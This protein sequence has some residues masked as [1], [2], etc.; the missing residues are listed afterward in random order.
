MSHFISHFLSSPG[1]SP[2]TGQD[3]QDGREVE[4]QTSSTHI[5]WRYVGE[6]NWTDLIALSEL[7][8]PEGPPG[9]KGDTGEAGAT[10]AP[11]ADGADGAD[12]Q[13]VTITVLTDPSAFE[14]ATPGALELV[15]LTD[16]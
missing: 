2:G 3:G 6:A 7:E 16:A 1:A 10:G 9:Q 11:G 14:A 12:G 13:N 15:V 5:Q 4:F 8:G